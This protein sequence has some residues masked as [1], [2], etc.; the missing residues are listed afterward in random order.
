MAGIT[1]TFVAN[2]R[3][4]LTFE[5]P[6]NGSVF[7]Q[8]FEASEFGTALFGRPVAYLSPASIDDSVTGSPTIHQAL[9]LDGLDATQWGVASVAEQSPIHAAEGFDSLAFGVQ[10]RARDPANDAAFHFTAP[11]W[12]PL[13]FRW[14]A[15]DTSAY[16]FPSAIPAEP[17]PAP[18]VSGT[19]Q[20]VLA[21]GWSALGIG[22]PTVQGSAWFVNL[23][24]HGIV[25][26]AV[27]PQ[28]KPF[29]D[30]ARRTLRP[31]SIDATQWGD[32]FMG[33]GVRWVDHAGRGYGGPTVGTAFVAYAVRELQPLWFA[34]WAVPNPLVGFHREVAPVGTDVAEFGQAEVLDNTQRAYPP[35]DTSQ[36]EWGANRI[37]HYQQSVYPAGLPARNEYGR[38]TVFPWH[39]YLFPFTDHPGIWGPYYPDFTLVEHRNKTLGTAGWRDS[40]HGWETVVSLAGLPYFPEGWDSATFG[41]HLVAD[42]I[43]TVAVEAWD[44]QDFGRWLVVYNDARV[45]AP[46]GGDFAALGQPNVAS[47]R[48]W[49]TVVHGAS[50]GDAGWPMVADRIR[51]VRPYEL[52]PPYVPVPYAHHQQEFLAPTGILPK[53]VGAHALYEFRIVI[54]PRWTLRDGYGEPRVHNVTPELPTWGY[55]QSE[56]GHARV[57]LQWRIVLPQGDDSAAPGPPAVEFRTRRVWPFPIQA[58]ALVNS[59]NTRVRKALPDPPAPQHVDLDDDGIWPPNLGIAAHRVTSNV[60]EHEQTVAFTGYGN[61]VVSANSLRPFGI[62]LNEIDQYGIPAL[63]ATQWLV[64]E[65]IEPVQQDIDGF[66]P[67]AQHRV[68]PWT[69]WACTEY[70]GPAVLRKGHIIDYPL[71]GGSGGPGWGQ[72]VI[73][74]HPAP[75]GPQG[76]QSDFRSYGEPDIGHWRRWLYPD[77]VKSFHY[78]VPVLPTG[79]TVKPEGAESAGIGEPG[80]AH[81]VNPLLPR[82]VYPVGLWGWLGQLTWISNR[83]REIVPGAWPAGGTAPGVG[84]PVRVGPPVPVV[85]IGWD[86]LVIGAAWP[87]HRIRQVAVEGLDATEMWG[88]SLATIRD[89]LRVWRRS[90]LPVITWDSMSIGEPRLSLRVQTIAAT[91]HDETTIALPGARNQNRV[92]LAGWDALVIGDIDRW[93]TGKLKPYGDD[94]LTCGVPRLPRGVRPVTW[95][96]ACGAPAM[97]HGIAP[98]AWDDFGSSAPVLVADHCGGRAMALT[99]SD[100]AN[101]GSGNVQ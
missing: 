70:P 25:P 24:T 1:I 101:F 73:S 58:F 39:Q 12:P 34:P 15:G 30:F 82:R 80:L 7:G 46:G 48:R 59:P 21:E 29:V 93:E 17:P 66:A 2:S 77:G 36:T 89:R 61:P 98:A 14:P 50:D 38:P 28:D 79:N 60:L 63:N 37:S 85:G 55:D 62:F 5:W 74:L 13:T 49:L 64:A 100:F 35:S 23:S 16:L 41:G 67:S 9:N 57:R 56:W 51:F 86:S 32:A 11:I 91:G 44:S 8:G 96:G 40:R 90:A 83:V 18:T 68:D 71:Y 72:A 94:L 88:Y 19:G 6:L 53:E 27:S 87:S 99:G 95:D 81:Y 31:D 47:N 52:P 76:I 54:T 69:I 92:T 33:G 97:A 84:R 65:G 4:S 20:S 22:P 78:G 75:I 42:R 3:A 10:V 45:I 26:P 43:R